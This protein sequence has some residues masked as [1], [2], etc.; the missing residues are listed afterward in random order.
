MSSREVIRSLLD[1]GWYEVNVSGSHHH[2]AHKEKKGKVT[3]PHP[4]KDLPI[5]TLKSIERQ[6][7]IKLT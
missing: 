2:F 6:A 5:G 7:G 4:K 1:D 3:V